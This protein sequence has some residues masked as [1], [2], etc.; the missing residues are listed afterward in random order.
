MARIELALIVWKT[1][2]L[3]LYDTCYTNILVIWLLRCISPFFQCI[4]NPVSLDIIGIALQ[5]IRT[6][7]YSSE[8]SWS[9]VNL[10]APVKLTI[11]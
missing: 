4:H 2:I 9:T 5:K 7:I 11:K 1:K 6:P 3:P 8:E 10:A